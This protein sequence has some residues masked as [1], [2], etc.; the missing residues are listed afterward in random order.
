MLK[1]FY[2]LTF[3]QNKDSKIYFVFGLHNHQPIGN[4]ASVFDKAFASCYLP[5][6]SILEKFPQIKAVIH[7]SGALYSYAQANV[8]G[9]IDKLKQLVE[10]GQIE[11]VGGGYYEPI[12][13]IVGQEDRV[14]QIK[15]MNQFLEKAF[16]KTPKGCWVPERVWEPSLAKTLNQTGFSYTYLDQANFYQKKQINQSNESFYLTE[17]QGYPLGL[18]VI[19]EL[20]ADKIPFVKPK[21]VIDILI[22]RKKKE[23]VLVNFFCDGEKFGLWPG[24]YDLVYKQGWLEEF[25]TLLARNPEIE[26]ITSQQAAKKFAKKDLTYIEASTYPKMQR[27]ALTYQDYLNYQNLD[28]L[29]KED[30]SYKK[31]RQFIRGESFKNFFIKYPRLNFMHKRMLNLAKKINLSLDYNSKDKDAFLNLWKAQTNCAYWHGIFGGFYLPH[32]RKACYDYLIKAEAILDKKL[33]VSEFFCQ[34]IDFDSYSEIVAKREDKTYVF[35]ELGGSLDELSL[36]DIPTNLINTINR[37]KEP[38]H[39]KFKNH[40]LSRYLIYDSYKKVCLV[41]HLIKKEL[42]S[43]EFAQG[44]GVYSLANQAYN[45]SKVK[46]KSFSFSYQEKDISFIKNIYLDKNSL[47]AKYSFKKNT[48]NNLG[49]GIEFNLS[50]SGL[51]SLFIESG[52]GIDLA[53][54]QEL[55]EDSSF[56]IV[57]KNYQLKLRFSFNPAKVYTNPIYT[58][59]SSES[60]EEVLFQQLAI[61]FYL[62]EKKE[63]FNLK[64]DI[65]SLRK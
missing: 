46:D 3:M 4:L 32:L 2:S 56:T 58:L 41:D 64:L 17:D 13:S 63:A 10:C 54:Q 21:E 7:N 38:Y 47:E 19:D 35:S 6:L 37:V 15:L 43:Q 26:T 22:S 33:G 57:D 31:Y 18:F 44:A 16:A 60:G 28:N 53:K 27:W 62:P 42:T 29:L 52:E 45:F 25:F 51:N 34:D 20:L 61:L 23:D 48:L 39:D 9:W 8:S 36:K 49:F 24:S 59:S 40:E 14:G 12:F 55:G 50:L 65:E 30:K 1:F 5:F 11:I